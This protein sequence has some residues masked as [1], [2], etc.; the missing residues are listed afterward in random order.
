[1][2]VDIVCD[3]IHSRHDPKWSGRLGRAEGGG[4]LVC[5]ACVVEMMERDDVAVRHL[6][7]KQTLHFLSLAQL[8]VCI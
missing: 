2:S 6:R 7:V 3:K 1:M 4:P 5:V 8:V